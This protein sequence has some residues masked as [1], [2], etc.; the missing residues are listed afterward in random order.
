MTAA[1]SHFPIPFK[2][3]VVIQHFSNNCNFCIFITNIP[4]V[5]VILQVSKGTALFTGWYGIYPVQVWCL[6]VWVQCG[7]TR[8]AV[9]PCSTLK[10]IKVILDT[11]SPPSATKSDC[12]P[13]T[14]FDCRNQHIIVFIHLNVSQMCQEA[15]SNHGKYPFPFY[16]TKSGNCPPFCCF[17]AT[18]IYYNVYMYYMYV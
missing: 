2:Y 7:K 13:S 8:P 4:W 10:W 17:W 15:S 11:L 6:Q 9:Y 16:H 18:K 3:Y 5:S 14:V 12:H 1:V